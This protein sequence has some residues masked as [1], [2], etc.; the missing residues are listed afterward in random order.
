MRDCLV[1]YYSTCLFI[2]PIKDKNKRKIIFIQKIRILK[3]KFTKIKIKI[4]I[5]GSLPIYPLSERLESPKLF[6]ACLPSRK[7]R[8]GVYIYSAYI[9][10][11]FN[12]LMG[13]TKLK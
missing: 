2:P 1:L 13:H 5:L 8:C 6:M 9:N 11:G 12:Y 10:V 7:Q 3:E 4:I